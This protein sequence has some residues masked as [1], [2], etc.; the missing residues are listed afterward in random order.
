MELVDIRKCCKRLVSPRILYKD[1]Q[2]LTLTHGDMMAVK[3]RVFEIRFF[4]SN[5]S[6][7]VR[8]SPFTSQHQ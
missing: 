1:L 5:S 8:T 6:R 4:A 7:D 2:F 3:V